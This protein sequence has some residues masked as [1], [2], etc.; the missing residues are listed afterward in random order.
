MMTE[1]LEKARADP[2]VVSYGIMRSVYSTNT[3]QFFA[4]VLRD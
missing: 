2:Q 3:I 1:V 4:C